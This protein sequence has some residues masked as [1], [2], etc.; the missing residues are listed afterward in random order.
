MLHN[1][2]EDV[3]RIV[4]LSRANKLQEVKEGNSMEPPR[5][6]FRDKDTYTTENKPSMESTKFNLAFDLYKKEIRDMKLKY[7][8]LSKQLRSKDIELLN[9][10]TAVEASK[11][12]TQQTTSEPFTKEDNLK[13]YCAELEVCAKLVHSLNEEGAQEH[14]E[15]TA[16]LDEY[17]RATTKINNYVEVMKQQSQKLEQFATLEKNL[18]HQLSE[19]K[20]KI[21]SLECSEQRACA[22]KE[23]QSQFIGELLATIDI[24]ALEVKEERALNCSLV[25]SLAAAERENAATLTTMQE[26]TAL[27]TRTV[28][29]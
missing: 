20:C 17:R 12:K 19:C 3:L 15:L 25:K 14:A 1:K 29:T 6:H 7:E 5:D 23:Q 21:L 26:S 13:K 2:L 8:Q 27:Y 24:R 11:N 10:Q 22:E 18:L 16:L 9:L 28:D 4:E